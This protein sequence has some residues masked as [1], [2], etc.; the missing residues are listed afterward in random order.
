MTARALA[1]SDLDL[2]RNVNAPARLPVA[3]PR[4]ELVGPLRNA[5]EQGLAAVADNGLSG[6]P[7]RSVHRL[8]CQVR[9]RHMVDGQRMERG[10]GNADAV[11]AR[12]QVP[13]DPE[14]PPESEVVASSGGD[15]HGVI[16]GEVVF[17]S[18]DLPPF[19]VPVSMLVPPLI[20]EHPSKAGGA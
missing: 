13:E 17:R 15:R 16:K 10:E 14:N 5:L 4:G 19:S 6:L 7:L 11:S 8:E 2:P 20:Q 9:A 1:Q 3:R 18:G 12:S